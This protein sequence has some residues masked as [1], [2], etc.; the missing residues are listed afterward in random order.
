MPAVDIA[1]VAPDHRL[2]QRVVVNLLHIGKG[3][4]ITSI[5][6]DSDGIAEGKYFFHTVRN[7]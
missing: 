5:F 3:F 7:V 1:N 4:D 6:K 2:H